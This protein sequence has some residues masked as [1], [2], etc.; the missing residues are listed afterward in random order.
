MKHILLLTDAPAAPLFA[1]RMRY[2][3]SNLAQQ[4]WK[5]IV[6]SERMPNTDFTFADCT[7]LQFR[8]YDEQPTLRNKWLWLMDKLFNRKENVFYR[9]VKQ[10]VQPADVDYILCSSFNTLPL[11]SAARLAKEWRK[12]L[13]A[14]IRDMAEQWGDTPFM[15]NPSSLAKLNRWL[16]KLYTRR[17]IRQRNRAL[18]T[19]SAVV[20]ISPWHQQVLQRYCK[21]VH[22]IYNGYDEHRFQPQDCQTTTF[23]ITYTG[24][25]FDFR[26]RNPLLLFKALAA[27]QKEHTLPDELQVHFYCEDSIHDT[28]RQ[29]AEQ[30][31]ITTI[32]H[33]HS[34]VSNDEVLE[35]LRQTSVSV[36]LTNKP[37][38]HGP[39]GLM[40][41]KFFEALG[42]EKPTLCVTSDEECLATVIRETNAGIAATSSDE[43]KAFIRNNYQEWKTKG[44]TRQP[45]NAEQKQRFSRQYQAQQFI[46]LFQT[47]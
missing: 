35:I 31:N 17:S 42:V 4:G 34:F 11:P 3:I 46:Q 14:D 15:Q 38:E 25:I 44:F 6:V 7:H 33:I 12:P 23:N 18:Q 26:L 22:L 1:P 45:V 39:H 5:W 10:H 30:H 28:L 37:D 9:F 41:T 24:R 47:L 2:L 8:Y 27:M 20:T 21:S 40:T 19:A 43:V 29:Q 13:V 16:T 36:I 32:L